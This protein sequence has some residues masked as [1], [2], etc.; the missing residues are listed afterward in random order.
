MGQQGK[1]CLCSREVVHLGEVGRK[2]SAMVPVVKDVQDIFF[3]ASQKALVSFWKSP[4]VLWSFDK[5]TV[6]VMWNPQKVPLI[7]EAYNQ[8]L[9]GI[10]R[11]KWLSVAKIAKCA[12]VQW[13]TSKENGWGKRRMI[14]LVP[15]FP[16]L[17]KFHLKSS[18]LK[19][20]PAIPHFPSLDALTSWNIHNYHILAIVCL[21]T[22]TLVFE[23]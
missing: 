11:S 2:K 5:S 14:G 6:F 3:S 23:F 13:S 20:W 1:A 8:P 7:L 17:I 9:P 19:L 10:A 21:E 15:V 4:L 16:F 12:L 22:I 18:S